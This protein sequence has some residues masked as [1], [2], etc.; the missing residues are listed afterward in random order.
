MPH[1]KADSASLEVFREK[2]QE[3]LQVLGLDGPQYP[4]PVSCPL[5]GKD[6]CAP[7]DGQVHSFPQKRRAER[8]ELLVKFQPAEQTL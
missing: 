3:K 5:W 6:H 8:E 4:F 2:E 7:S 1:L